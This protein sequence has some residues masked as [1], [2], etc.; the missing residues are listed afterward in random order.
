MCKSLHLNLERFIE[1]RIKGL[2]GEEEERGGEEKKILGN[3]D[4]K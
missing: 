2:R 1:R 3:S 4:T